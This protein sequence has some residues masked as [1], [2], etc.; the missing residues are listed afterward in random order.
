MGAPAPSPWI[1]AAGTSNPFP[2][3]AA[4]TRQYAPQR[5]NVRSKQIAGVLGQPR[6]RIPDGAQQLSGD[7]VA[8]GRAEEDGELSAAAQRDAPRALLLERLAV[9]VLSDSLGPGREHLI[10]Q[11][12][13]ERTGGDRVD[14]N[15]M[16]AHSAASVS[17]KRTAAAF[18]AAYALRK[19]SGAVAPPPESCTILP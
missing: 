4:I 10:E 16:L 11:A 9:E 15:A 3:Q 13:V 12:C 2:L 19:G 8:G 6:P 18:E 5:V 17:A 14:V 1:G 7:A